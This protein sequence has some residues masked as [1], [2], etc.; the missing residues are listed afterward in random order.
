MGYTEMWKRNELN[1]ILCVLLKK[2]MI[3]RTRGDIRS[4][5]QRI[6][7]M[8]GR[9]RRTTH[10]LHRVETS[11]INSYGPQVQI[12]KLLYTRRGKH[13][14]FSIRRSCVYIS[15]HIHIRLHVTYIS[16]L[17]THT[18]MVRFEKS[19][20]FPAESFWFSIVHIGHYWTHQRNYIYHRIIVYFSVCFL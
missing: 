4:Y 10:T 3:F 16:E 20:N 18:E 1:S 5:V 6:R 17:H 7:E 14:S 15:T 19:R 2:G 11:S 12:W 8:D 13:Y 9:K